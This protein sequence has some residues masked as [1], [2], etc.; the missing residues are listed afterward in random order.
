MSIQLYYTISFTDNSKSSI[1]VERPHVLPEPGD[2]LVFSQRWCTPGNRWYETGDEIHLH[3]RTQEAP[4]FRL[5]SLGNWIAISKYGVSIWSN[6]EWMM[7][8]GTVYISQ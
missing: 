6:I 2:I 4:N 8:Q 1:E 5:S 7:S 3:E